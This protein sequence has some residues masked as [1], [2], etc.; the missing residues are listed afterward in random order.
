LADYSILPTYFVSQLARK[1][2]TVCLGGDGGDELFGGYDWYTQHRLLQKQVILPKVIRGFTK[3]AIKNISKSHYTNRIADLINPTNN[4]SYHNYGKLRSLLNYNDLNSLNIDKKTVDTYKTFFKWK[5][6]LNNLLYS[7]IKLY[8]PE[9][10]LTKVDRASMAHSLEVRVPFLDH[11]FV[12]FSGRIPPQLKI[13]YFQKKYVLK[14]AM[15]NI[16]PKSTIYKKKRGFGVPLK[17]YFRKELKSYVTEKLLESRTGDKEFIK[18]IL[19]QHFSCRRD[20]SHLIWNNLM[21]E[22]WKKRWLKEI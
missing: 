6:H 20:H 22:E 18:K 4:L 3:K 14:K 13:K 1:H 10:I 8:L 21:L 2:V 11:N 12:E 5:N 16:L 15:K 17:Q 19:S 9:Q 7:D